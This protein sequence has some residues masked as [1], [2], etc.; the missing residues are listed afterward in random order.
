MLRLMTHPGAGPLKT[1]AFVHALLR[2]LL[3]EAAQA[4]PCVLT[5]GRI[6]KTELL[7]GSHKAKRRF[8][9]SVS[10]SQSILSSRPLVRV[11]RS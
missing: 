3:V 10:G 4:I 9:T 5:Q 8:L 7:S 11:V 2:F 1:L 6:L